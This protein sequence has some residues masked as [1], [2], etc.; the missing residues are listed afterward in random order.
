MKASHIAAISSHDHL[1]ARIS[2]HET[3]LIPNEPTREP[4]MS[5]PTYLPNLNAVYERIAELGIICQQSARIKV[6]ESTYPKYGY[7]VTLLL[8]YSTLDKRPADAHRYAIA[9]KFHFDGLSELNYSRI[10]RTAKNLHPG[11]SAGQTAA[12]AY[13][14]KLLIESGHAV[15]L[16]RDDSV[17]QAL[18][19]SDLKNAG[20]F[21]AELFEKIAQTPVYAGERSLDGSQG[22]ITPEMNA[23]C[24]RTTLGVDYVHTTEEMLLQLKDQ[25][26]HPLRLRAMQ[27]KDIA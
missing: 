2:R 6:Y 1:L 26:T 23:A 8:D 18:R 21:D 24:L 13:C 27:L 11:T 19:E 10:V 22:L 7:S 25:G 17:L 5:T 16:Y 9:A 15:L 3:V 14:A 20:C 12:E 4:A